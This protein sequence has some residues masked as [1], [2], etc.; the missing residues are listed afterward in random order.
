MPFHYFLTETTVLAEKATGK[1]IYLLPPFSGVPGDTA[2]RSNRWPK[3][4]HGPDVT[5][6]VEVVG[7]NYRTVGPGPRIQSHGIARGPGLPAGIEDGDQFFLYP[8]EEMPERKTVPTN[9]FSVKGLNVRSGNIDLI[10][11]KYLLLN[12]QAK[13][14]VDFEYLNCMLPPHH[15][16]PEYLLPSLS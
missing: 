13:A 3:P 7:E 1:R 11:V 2:I 10:P 16:Y 6:A 9:G 14:S 4:L 8:P 12:P 15:E 5:E